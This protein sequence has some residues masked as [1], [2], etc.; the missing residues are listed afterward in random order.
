MLAGEKNGELWES[1][2]ATGWVRVPG[3]ETA[4]ANGLELSADG[5]TLYVAAWGSQ[6]FYRLSRG[7]AQPTRDEITLGFRVDNIHFARDGALYATG[8]VPQGWKESSWSRRPSVLPLGVGA[9][10]RLLM[11][12]PAL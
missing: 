6:S 2:T 9:V 4:G 8:Q 12:I 3:S 10:G 7:A 1:H 11:G 5:N